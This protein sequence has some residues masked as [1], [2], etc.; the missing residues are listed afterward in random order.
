[1]QTVVELSGKSTS[2]EYPDLK[3]W[4][5]KQPLSDIRCTVRNETYKYKQ[6]EVRKCKVHLERES[7]TWDDRLSLVQLRLEFLLHGYKFWIYLS[8][9]PQDTHSPVNT[10]LL[11]S[12]SQIWVYSFSQRPLSQ[13]DTAIYVQN[14]AKNK[15]KYIHG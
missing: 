8:T 2:H 1:M 4:K 15:T 7:F 10:L 13:H 5:S 9:A 6:A 11:C 3:Y 12:L 14:T